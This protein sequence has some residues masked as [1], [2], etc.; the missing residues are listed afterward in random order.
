MLHTVEWNICD[1]L[2][3]ERAIQIS[4]KIRPVGQVARVN[5]QQREPIKGYISLCVKYIPD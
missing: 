3:L 5:T 2:E 4:D 1:E